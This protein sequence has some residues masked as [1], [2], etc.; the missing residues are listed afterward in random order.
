MEAIQRA[1]RDVVIQF[2][3]FIRYEPPGSSNKDEDPAIGVAPQRVVWLV[4]RL[5]TTVDL[6][7]GCNRIA[8]EHANTRSSLRAVAT[9]R[10]DREQPLARGEFRTQLKAEP[11]Y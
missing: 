7:K 4:Q 1:S 11:A 9:L 3:F 2:I 10:T 6:R 8:Q 5:L